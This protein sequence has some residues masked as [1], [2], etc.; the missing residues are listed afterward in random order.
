VSQKQLLAQQNEIDSGNA[1]IE[2]LRQQSEE[3]KGKNDLIVAQKTFE[4]D[5]AATLG[6]FDRQ[7]LIM[8]T[9]SRTFTLLENPQAMRLKK[10]G[11]I[12][13]RKFITQPTPEEL[14]DALG[15]EELELPGFL[16]GIFGGGDK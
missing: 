5:Q 7:V 9:D 15:P 10:A 13:G 2:R 12:D 1:L 14:E 11:F 4:N 3:N 8:N 16:K 6:P